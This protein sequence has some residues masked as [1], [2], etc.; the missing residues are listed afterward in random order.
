MGHSYDSKHVTPQFNPP[1]SSL[2]ER[3]F[4]RSFIFSFGFISFILPIS[5]TTIMYVPHW[6]SFFNPPKW[7]MNPFVSGTRKWGL[8]S[9]SSCPLVCSTAWNAHMLNLLKFILVTFKYY[10]IQI[11]VVR[12]GYVRFTCILSLRFCCW[13]S[14]FV[15][16]LR[17]AFSCLMSFSLSPA[18]SS[19]S[20]AERD[21]SASTMTSS[22]CQTHR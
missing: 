20:D 7:S 17:R 13:A 14:L 9:S 8:T 6:R 12:N 5:G 22:A 4:F 15:R 1:S 18:S 19:P 10:H 16:T 21:D 2:Q 11:C 3:V